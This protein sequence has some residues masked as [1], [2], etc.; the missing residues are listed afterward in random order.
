MVNHFQ[1]TPQY[2]ELIE[3]EIR[4]AKELAEKNLLP[5]TL[6]RLTRKNQEPVLT[7]N[8]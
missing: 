1:N 5:S 8:R 4:E 2:T 3:K 6:I 7:G